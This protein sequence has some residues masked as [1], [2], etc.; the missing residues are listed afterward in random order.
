MGFCHP[1]SQV[2][3]ASPEIVALLRAGVAEHRRICHRGDGRAGHPS[4]AYDAIVSR[5]AARRFRTRL[6]EPTA[7][8]QRHPDGA[9]GGPA[10]A[11]PAAG[12][13]AIVC[14]WRLRGRLEKGSGR[15]PARR[16]PRS[17]ADERHGRN[18][19][20][21]GRLNRT[22]PQSA[23]RHATGNRRGVGAHRSVRAMR[24][25]CDRRAIPARD[26]CREPAL[27]LARGDPGS[28]QAGL[29]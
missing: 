10:F 19:A 4:R 29:G 1:L 26:N 17:S 23:A 24:R 3:V 11:A 22:F 28:R 25:A 21:P 9:T 2:R 5:P 16:R 27:R 7:L 13:R 20:N 8:L 6:T 14:R 15:F 12:T 18:P